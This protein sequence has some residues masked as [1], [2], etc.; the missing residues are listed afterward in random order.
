MCSYEGVLRWWRK[1]AELRGIGQGNRIKSDLS[2]GL[3]GIENL[4][5][6]FIILIIIYYIYYIFNRK[7][8]IFTIFTDQFI[9]I[10]WECL[11][12]IIRRR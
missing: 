11:N 2:S 9:V 3:A 12:T 7:F 1:G 6:V 5:Y 10:S 8:I 4:L